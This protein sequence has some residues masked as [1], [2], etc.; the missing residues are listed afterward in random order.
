M[1]VLWLCSWY[2]NKL[3]LFDGD[4]IQ[5]H[6]KAV[7]SL[8]HVHVCFIKKDEEGVITKKVKEESFS[9][10]NLT[11]TI[12]YYKP[13][14]TGLSFID[15]IISDRQYKK[16]YKR[17]LYNYISTNE[18]LNFVH[19][20][21]AFKA[22]LAALWLKNK[23]NIPF[24]ISEHWSGYLHNASYRYKN[25]S[26]VN[27]IRLKN[28]FHEAEKLTVVSNVLGEAI[29]KN[30]P[31]E[32]FSVIPNVVDTE[33]FYPPAKVFENDSVKFI[34]VSSLNAEKNIEETIKA[35]SIVKDKGYDF[36]L[37]VYGP[38][39]KFLN[40]LCAEKKLDDFITLKGE[41][42]QLLLADKMRKH[43]ALVLFSKYETF[44]C[45]VIEANACG[46]PAILTDL[47]VFREYV[48][49]NETGIF[50]ASNTANDLVEAII[51]F[52]NNRQKFNKKEISEYAKANFQYS[53]IAAKFD[54]IY[55]DI[56]K[57]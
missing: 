43:D 25:F 32:S 2:P 51:Y 57:E 8:H 50:A 9:D 28:I 34:H 49:E 37:T 19:V 36:S 53:A 13:F 11:E 18:K 22:G 48:V 15:K 30:F 45:V 16:L 21:V 44:G 41:I 20:H 6:A 24:L 1:K 3:G 4:F 23:Y 14:K 46:L 5:R 40:K 12:I 56:Y 29:I 7:S 42:S 47:R 33:I 26:K 27:L 52:I 38:A 17:F 31:V 10:L 39:K 55:N 35:F 54:E